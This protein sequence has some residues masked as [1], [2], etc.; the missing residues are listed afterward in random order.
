M[1]AAGTEET[2]NNPRGRLELQRPYRCNGGVKDEF[3][4]NE[5]EKMN[6]YS[7][8]DMNIGIVNIL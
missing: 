3:K 4:R 1:Y 6:Q 7:K 2:E 5:K 8:A